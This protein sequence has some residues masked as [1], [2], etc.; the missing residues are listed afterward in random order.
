VDLRGP[1]LKRARKPRN[2]IRPKHP[3]RL[4]I[5]DQEGLRA[6]IA[7]TEEGD[8]V[9]DSHP[10]LIQIWVIGRDEIFQFVRV[11]MVMGTLLEPQ[12]LDG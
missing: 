9:T 10:A 11:E 7:Y 8:I 6:I 5:N 12:Q 2:E 1:G 3:H 4:S